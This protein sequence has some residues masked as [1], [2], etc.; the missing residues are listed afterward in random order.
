MKVKVRHALITFGKNRSEVALRGAIVDLP[1]DDA[2]RFLARGAV[3]PSD[4]ELERPGQLMDLRESPSDE[5]LVSWVTAATPDEVKALLTVRPNLAPR[6]VAATEHVEA[7]YAYQTSR[8]SEL[9]EHAASVEVPDP[10][11]GTSAMLDP[12]AEPATDA[13]ETDADAAG[14]ADDDGTDDNDS[15][16]A[17]ATIDADT[18][19]VIVGGNVE[20][21]ENHLADNPENAAL[22]LEAEH[23]RAASEG[24]PPRKGVLEAVETAL[25]YTSDDDD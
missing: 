23:R 1:S 4:Q 12:D 22:V 10:G 11:H 18:A 21:V 15:E 5:E 16:G 2:E 7:L 6:V 20:T 13:D 3:I 14:G 19:D 25:S 9:A 24:K 8:L 17:D